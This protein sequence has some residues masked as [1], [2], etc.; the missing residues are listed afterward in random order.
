MHKDETDYY[1]PVIG[2]EKRCKSP[3]T[4]KRHYTE[5]GPH[6]IEELLRAGIP[7]WF[8]LLNTECFVNDT[9][10]WLTK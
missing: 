3:I 10:K 2:C 1:C 7:A 6:R 8:Y 9:G 5:S 4:L